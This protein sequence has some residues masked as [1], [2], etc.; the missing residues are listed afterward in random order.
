MQIV[1]MSKGT[2]NCLLPRKKHFVKKIKNENCVQ[3]TVMPGN[4]G[5]LNALRVLE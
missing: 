3:L 5:N 4:Y 1:F 2:A